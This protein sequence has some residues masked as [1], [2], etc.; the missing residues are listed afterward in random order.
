MDVVFEKKLNCG[1]YF[2]SFS[3][4]VVVEF[5]PCWFVASFDRGEVMG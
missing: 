3:I 4:W 1:I 5:D 2:L